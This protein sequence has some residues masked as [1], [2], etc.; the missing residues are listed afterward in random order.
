MSVVKFPVTQLGECKRE[1]SSCF[2]D[3]DIGE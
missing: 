3:I 2:W 1:I